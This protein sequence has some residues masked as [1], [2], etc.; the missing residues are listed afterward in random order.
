MSVQETVRRYLYSH[1]GHLIKAGDAKYDEDKGVYR[2]ELLS[3]Y[4]RIIRDD[5]SPDTPIVRFLQLPRLGEVVVS[6]DLSIVSATSDDQC[7]KAVEDYLDLIKQRSERIMVQASSEKFATMYEVKHVLNPIIKIV[8]NLVDSDENTPVISWVDISAEPEK[9]KIVQYLN[10]LEGIEIVKQGERGV[11]MGNLLV[12]FC[13]KAQNKLPDVQNMVL[14]HVI[15]KGYAALRSFHIIT[16]IQPYIQVDNCYYWQ[17]IDAEKNLSVKK[18]K[19]YDRF[20][21]HY[22]AISPVTFRSMLQ[23]LIE[24]G[25]LHQ[26]GPY[27][28]ADDELLG[29]MIELKGSQFNSVS[30]KA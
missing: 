30:I 1:Y 14:S 17:A 18:S 28:Y 16:Q 11:T 24:A 21:T 2:A 6:P 9:E 25:A 29:R 8:N 15:N 3:S 12:T 26:D 19:M 5:K 13:M 27:C 22:D 20:V 10:L 7:E 23:E 4:P